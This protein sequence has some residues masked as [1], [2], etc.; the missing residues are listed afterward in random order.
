MLRLTRLGFAL[1]LGLILVLTACNM[2][3]AGTAGSTPVSPE[4]IAQTAVVETISAIQS[5][6]ALVP[7]ATVAPQEP[8]ATPTVAFTFTP[9]PTPQDPLVVKDA[10]C[11]LGPGPVYEVSSSVKTGIR[12]QLLGRG[13]VGA[14]WIIDNPRYHEPCWL[15]ADVLQFDAGYDLT[16]LKVFNPPPTP[17]PIPTDT[18]TP[19]NTPHP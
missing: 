16:N 10:L 11:W 12:V 8:S 5:Q 9:F 6:T 2:P 14:W 7:T 4:L 15:Q 1:T 3:G 18:P 13:S 19:T 17:T